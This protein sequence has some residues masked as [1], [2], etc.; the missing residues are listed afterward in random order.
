MAASTKPTHFLLPS[1]PF[2]PVKSA[3]T[4]LSYKP[5]FSRRAGSLEAA[6]E[7]LDAAI[8]LDTKDATDREE[9]AKLKLMIFDLPGAWSDLKVHAE[10]RSGSTHRTINPM[11]SHAGQ[12]YEE[13]ILDTTLAVQL[14]A[15]REAQPF[16]Q[17]AQLIRL[18]REFQIPRV[19]PS[20]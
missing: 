19:L 11:H 10:T 18:V 9:R 14:R 7:H 12:L 5:N 6:I 2:C 3:G 20:A 1:L 16:E 17:V 13:Y 4:C 15:L 8:E